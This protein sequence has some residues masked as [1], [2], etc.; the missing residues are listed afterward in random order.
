MSGKLNSDP[1]DP[2]PNAA[3]N[4]AMVLRGST[5][6]TD[7][8]GY[9]K[10][11]DGL[12]VLPEKKG[13]FRVRYVLMIRYDATMVKT[14]RPDRKD[15]DYW[16]YQAIEGFPGLV[17]G[18]HRFNL[19]WFLSESLLIELNH[20]C[21]FLSHF[22]DINRQYEALHPCIPC[23]QCCRLHGCSAEVRCKLFT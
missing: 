5:S 20:H 13:H 7:V 19:F 6:T 15:I 17:N 16:E 18:Q 8:V 23:R 9:T 14:P 21:S 1:R 4:I 3:E 22:V 2:S 11:D 12:P 10:N